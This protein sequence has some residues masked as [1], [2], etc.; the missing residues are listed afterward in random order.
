V[1]KVP[2]VALHNV[3]FGTMKL[4][5]ESVNVPMSCKAALIFAF[6]EEAEKSDIG[7]AGAAIDEISRS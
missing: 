2:S 7:A 4:V 1:A 6:I 3:V 5:S